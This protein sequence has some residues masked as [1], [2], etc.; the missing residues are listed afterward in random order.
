M[1]QSRFFLRSCQLFFD[2]RK[3]YIQHF[4]GISKDILQKLTMCLN[5]LYKGDFNMR[6]KKVDPG[7]FSFLQPGWFALHTVLIAGATMLG[8]AWEKRT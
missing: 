6:F 2:K 4:T 5:K 1:S 3:A 7:P 8:K